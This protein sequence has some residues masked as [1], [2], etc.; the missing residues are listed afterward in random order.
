M[1]FFK[2]YW[3]I[4]SGP[5]A[6]ILAFTSVTLG[7]KSL[8]LQK[9]LR[10]ITIPSLKAYSEKIAKDIDRSGYRPD[11]IIVP[12]VKNAIIAHF[13]RNKLKSSPSVMVGFQIYK[14]DHA[15]V[16]SKDGFINVSTARSHIL[17]PDALK[18]Y[19]NKKILF[20]DSI[21]K[22]GSTMDSLRESLVALGFDKK[23]FKTCCLIR[24]TSYP[25]AV[26]PDYTYRTLE[27]QVVFPWG[28]VQI[29]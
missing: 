29:T 27:G 20:V 24:S 25:N 10:T 1:D 2:T 4:I 7:L 26:K 9:K 3:P 21:Q 19:A 12:D 13:V 11:L 22:S 16:P 6:I 18:K 23:N 14:A 8:N 15:D 5:L 28:V 17:L